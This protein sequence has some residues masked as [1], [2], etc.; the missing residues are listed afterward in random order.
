MSYKEASIYRAGTRCNSFSFTQ[1]IVIPKE[2]SYTKNC[3]TQGIIV[4]K[5]SSYPTNCHIQETVI[6]KEPLYPRFIRPMESSYPR[7]QSSHPKNHHTQ[8]IVTPKE[9]SHPKNHH[10]HGIVTPW[11]GH[12]QGIIRSCTWLLSLTSVCE[13]CVVDFLFTKSCNFRDHKDAG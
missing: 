8:G 12:T 4:P 13:F 3:D 2:S 10:N 6:P 5:E 7:S 1:E 11:N 9:S